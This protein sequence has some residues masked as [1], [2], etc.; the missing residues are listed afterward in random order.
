MVFRYKSMKISLLDIP[1]HRIEFE[2]LRRMPPLKDGCVSI[3]R[4]A[5]HLENSGW[6]LI[7]LRFTSIHTP[8]AK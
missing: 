3:R 2:Y 6:G 7:G 5:V 1:K 4:S 8:P